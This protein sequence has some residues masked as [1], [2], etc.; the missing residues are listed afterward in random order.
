TKTILQQRATD[1]EGSIV[2]V[3]AIQ[4]LADNYPNDPKIKNFLQ[5]CA[6]DERWDVRGAGIKA[7]AK[8]FRDQ[9]ELFF[10]IYYNCAVHDPFERKQESE[11]NPRR[12]A[13]E[14]IIKQYPQHS[15][16]L[17]LLRDRAK[18]DPDE[19][20]QKYAQKIL[21]RWGEEKE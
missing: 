7:L 5:Q 8:H 2:R 18:N 19:V 6:T 11:D 10:D 1:D 14:I 3:R 20:V 13:L 17:S 21:K 16:T 12:I 9:P 15:Q 4:V